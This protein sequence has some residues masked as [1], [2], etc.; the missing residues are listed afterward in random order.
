MKV[1][2]NCSTGCGAVS[3][4][5]G[6]CNKHYVRARKIEQGLTVHPERRANRNSMTAEETAASFWNLAD[7]SGGPDACWPVVGLRPMWNGYYTTRYWSHKKETCHRIAF[8]IANGRIDESNGRMTVL[9][10]CDNRACVNPAHLSVGTYSDN[11]KDMFA[12]ERDVW[13]TTKE[14]RYLTDEEADQIRDEYA[15]R[16]FTQVQLAAKHNV[17]PQTISGITRGISHLKKSNN[18]D[19]SG[20]VMA[21]ERRNEL[22][23]LRAPNDNAT[24]QAVD[25]AKES[26]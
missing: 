1:K 3:K 17:A 20:L 18:H 24:V 21:L 14:W 5:R 4:F 19:G 16:K 13:S 9:H 11:T 8:E 26:A 12:K 15:T 10:K 6:L 22:R 23:M 25:E 7:R 2:P